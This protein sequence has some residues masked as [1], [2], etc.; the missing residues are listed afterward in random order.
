M[1]RNQISI[2]TPRAENM[3]N[4]HGLCFVLDTNIWKSRRFLLLKTPLSAAFLYALGQ[5]RGCI[6]MPEILEQEI[7]KHMGRA[8]VDYARQLETAAEALRDLGI[9]AYKDPPLLE[10]H[11]LEVPAGRLKAL[12]TSIVRVPLSLDQVRRAVARVNNELPPNSPKN[13]QFKDT[14]VWEALLDLAGQYDV[15]FVT[16]DK[17]FFQN[18]DPTAGLSDGLKQ[19][20]KS[21]AVTVRIVYADQFPALIQELQQKVPHLDREAT[22]AAVIPVSAQEVRRI[23]E[24]H[25]TGLGDLLESSV[26][27]YLTGD[28]GVLAL[29]YDLRYR[30][31]GATE[32]NEG[33]SGILLLRGTAE[34][35]PET[36]EVRKPVLTSYS[37]YWE[38]AGE[39][40]HI[41]AWSRDWQERWTRPDVP[42][43][44]AHLLGVPWSD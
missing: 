33:Q 5:Q 13:Q 17:G 38:T 2:V 43:P 15:V 7:L 9:D 24:E 11:L 25:G 16:A 28:S 39:P 42:Q 1:G 41:E 29:D 18:R 30:F 20:C 6:G 12:G 10:S 22:R 14:L 26:T 31:T 27:P 35:L 3:M 44:P 40:T 23:A 8:A 21:L 32:Q 36:R 4:D 19:D 37:F 34:Y